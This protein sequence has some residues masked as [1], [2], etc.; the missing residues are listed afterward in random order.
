M[1]IAWNFS[2]STTIKYRMYITNTEWSPWYGIQKEGVAYKKGTVT[3]ASGTQSTAT[4]TIN[5][6]DVV[7]SGKVPY[8]VVLTLG[9]YQLPYINASGNV[10]TWISNLSNT[11]VTI[12]N[13]TSAW[14][15]YSYYLTVF[16]H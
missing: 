16:Y 15:N 6:S 10:V 1:Q 12:S 7:P 9:S 5:F 8:G 13:K 11:S 4:Q 14:S 3:I 2:S